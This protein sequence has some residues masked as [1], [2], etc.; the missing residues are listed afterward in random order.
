[1]EICSGQCFDGEVS[2]TYFQL[3]MDSATDIT[4]VE[5]ASAEPTYKK[6]WSLHQLIMILLQPLILT[7]QVVL[8]TE[9]GL[10]RQEKQRGRHFSPYQTMAYT[11]PYRRSHV[12]IQDFW[13]GFI[14][15]IPINFFFFI[16]KISMTMKYASPKRGIQATP[17]ESPTGSFSGQSTLST[18]EH[19]AQNPESRPPS[20]RLMQ[21]DGDY[22]IF[23]VF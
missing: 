4:S 17:N 18:R 9:A 8:Q 11:R 19:S 20:I 5:H 1:M 15:K 2:F 16:T 21:T 3:L 14:S 7:Y 6:S 22:E 12:W 23:S 13:K 10:G